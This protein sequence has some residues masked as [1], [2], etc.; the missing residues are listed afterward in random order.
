MIETIEPFEIK[1]ADRQRKYFDPVKLTELKESIEKEGLLQFPI[2]HKKDGEFHL[3]AGERRLKSMISLIMEGK[4]IR[5]LGRPAPEGTIPVAVFES[6]LE[7]L[8]AMRAELHE[9]IKRQDLTWQEAAAASAAIFKLRKQEDPEVTLTQVAQEINSH[10]GRNMAPSYLGTQILLADHMEL[11]PDVAKAK[12]MNDAYRL[13][14]DKRERELREAMAP[15]FMQ[16]EGKT[17]PHTFLLGNAEEEMLKLDPEQFDVI[18]TDPPYGIDV[19]KFAGQ[20]GPAYQHAYKD[21]EKYLKE[22]MDFCVPSFTRLTKP[23]AHLF[24]FCDIRFFWEWTVMLRGDD[25]DVWPRPLIWVKNVGHTP[26]P[27]QGP[28]RRYETIL[29]AIKGNMQ[30]AKVGSDVLVHAAPQGKDHPAQ[31]PVE[32][33]TEL[34]SW[35]LKFP[36]MTVLDPFC[37]SGTIFPAVHKFKG[38]ATGIENDPQYAV[39]CKQRIEECK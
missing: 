14:Q 18:L 5:F 15:V 39:F 8:D 36:G 12:N 21:S 7:L 6:E 11:H 28:A 17:G 26:R 24:L 27:Y 38:I 25:W 10:T 32:L 2:V 4:Q 19:D 35:S 1:V 34:L 3:V 23:D 22:L 31:K 13:L 37:G 20:G 9:N 33:Y 16:A 29:Y 30:V